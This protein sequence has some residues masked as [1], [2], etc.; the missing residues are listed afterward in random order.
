MRT[1][2]LPFM[3]LLPDQLDEA[4]KDLMD[5]RPSLGM[6]LVSLPRVAVMFH[7]SLYLLTQPFCWS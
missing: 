1:D 5:T 7:P 3:S 6:Y 2:R 4:T